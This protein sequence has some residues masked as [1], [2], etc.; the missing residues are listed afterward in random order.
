MS[1]GRLFNGVIQELTRP[2][3]ARPNKTLLICTLPR[4]GSN[5]LMEA[6]ISTAVYSSYFNHDPKLRDEWHLPTTAS[7][8]EYFTEVL[9]RTTTL[10]GVFGLKIHWHQLLSLLPRL[11]PDR[12]AQRSL[13]VAGHLTKYPLYLPEQARQAEAGNMV[14]SSITDKHMVAR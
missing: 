2:G 6:L 8:H 10:N 4:S 7:T 1:L 5:F 12:I 14:R 9:D 11:F 3:K 13:Q